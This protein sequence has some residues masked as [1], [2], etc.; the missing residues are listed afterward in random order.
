MPR[1][2]AIHSNTCTL[3]AISV[4]VK[5]LVLASIDL[6]ECR[7]IYSLKIAPKGEVSSIS[8][9]FKFSLDGCVS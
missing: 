3:H 2:V 6:P 4:Y 9:W 5:I 8:V 1:N 7:N